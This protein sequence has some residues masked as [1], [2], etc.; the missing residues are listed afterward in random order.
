MN[1]FIVATF[2]FLGCGYTE[3]KTLVTV[4]KVI[5]Q[6]VTAASI[7]MLVLRDVEMCTLVDFDQHH[8]LNEGNRLS[9]F[10]SSVNI[11]R[12][13]NAASHIT[14]LK[15]SASSSEIFSVLFVEEKSI[16]P[17]SLSRTVDILS[18]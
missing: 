6:V 9:S 10:E 18:Q 5:F 8:L 3:I 4:F 12:L 1:G 11:T 14:H 13:H 2:T 7:K 17:A 15:L 16:P